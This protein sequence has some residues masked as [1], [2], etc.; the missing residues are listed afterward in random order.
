MRI[1][2]DTAGPRIPGP[3]SS[4][5]RA[6]HLGCQGANSDASYGGSAFPR[7]QKSGEMK[8]RSAG[9]PGL[10]RAARTHPSGTRSAAG[11]LVL[12]LGI[13][14]LLASAIPTAVRA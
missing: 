5:R 12:V 2:T 14:A 13:G 10:P 7:G 11:A 1:T 8:T 4:G 6:D 3:N 9:D